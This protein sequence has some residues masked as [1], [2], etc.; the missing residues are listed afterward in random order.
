MATNISTI[1]IKAS[2]QKV[3]DALTKPELVKLLQ[4]GSELTTNWNVGSEI[5]FRTEWEGKVFEQWGTVL[6]MRTNEL[7]KYNCLHQDLTLQTS[8]KIIL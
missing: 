8:P 5:K 4:Y 3:W 2:T 7:I 6:E 1:N